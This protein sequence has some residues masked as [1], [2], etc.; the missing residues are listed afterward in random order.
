MTESVLIVLVCHR[1]KGIHGGE[2]DAHSL[3]HRVH[4][5]SRGTDRQTGITR[6]SILYSTNTW[7][8]SNISACAV[9]GFSFF[10]LFLVLFISP[11]GAL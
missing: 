11:P 3:R 9:L 6:V 5:G 7:V 8:W 10:I 1:L 2:Q 4:H